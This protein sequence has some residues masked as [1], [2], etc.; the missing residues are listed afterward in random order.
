[1]ITRSGVRTHEGIHPLD[2]KS[3]ALTIR[4]SWYTVLVFCPSMSEKQQSTV[5]SWRK[6]TIYYPPMEEDHSLLCTH[7]G[8]PVYC[9][10]MEENHNL[11]STHGGRPQSTM[12]PWRKTSLLSTNGGKP[13]S[14]IHPWRKTSLLSTHGGKPQS[15]IQPWRETTVYS[16]PMEENHSLLFN[17]GGKPVYCLLVLSTKKSEKFGGLRTVEVGCIPCRMFKEIEAQE[18]REGKEPRA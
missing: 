18:P 15:T 17:P 14:T 2:L 9:P 10:P 16:L 13:Q 11:L 12:H 6:T 1:M 8:K 5:H 4:P 7:G 3:N